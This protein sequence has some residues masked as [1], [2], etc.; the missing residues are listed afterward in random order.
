MHYSVKD[1]LIK[2]F[3]LLVLFFVWICMI[4]HLWVH[5]LWCYLFQMECKQD[6][7]WTRY[8]CYWD[9]HFNVRI[10][11]S[12]F[13][14]FFSYKP[15]GDSRLLKNVNLPTILEE[16]IFS[17]MIFVWLKT[18]KVNFIFLKLKVYLLCF[19]WKW[20]ATLSW[21]LLEIL[22]QRCVQN[23]VMQKKTSYKLF[24]E[25]WETDKRY[26]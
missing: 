26:V 16:L 3:C 9:L 15:N 11:I 4:E 10:S 7:T 5:I 18:I 22:S 13:S 14:L 19:L 24:C 20:R 8:G 17:W 1:I 12:L 25:L 21:L 23:D 6:I 2:W